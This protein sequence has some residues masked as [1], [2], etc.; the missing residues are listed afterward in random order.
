MTRTV[1]DSSDTLSEAGEPDTAI[2][3]RI[4]KALHMKC[5]M[6]MIVLVI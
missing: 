6:G 3:G 4:L 1:W 5:T 2:P